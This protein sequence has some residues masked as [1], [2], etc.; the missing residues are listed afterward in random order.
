MYRHSFYHKPIYN[1]TGK[2]QVL[3]AVYHRK[4]I[5]L[6]TLEQCFNMN[7]KQQPLRPPP[8]QLKKRGLRQYTSVVYVKREGEKKR[9]MKYP[10][11][12]SS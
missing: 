2:A 1:L 8:H 10:G 9:K 7:L 11:Y 5:N 4:Q 3:I 12:I 6:H